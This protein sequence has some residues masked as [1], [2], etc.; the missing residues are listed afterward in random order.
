MSLQVLMPGVFNNENVALQG[1]LAKIFFP[2]ATDK[3]SSDPNAN[4]VVYELRYSF[5]PIYCSGTTNSQYIYTETSDILTV[6]SWKTITNLIKENDMGTTIVQLPK[7]STDMVIRYEI[8]ATINYEGKVSSYVQAPDFFI[9]TNHAAQIE[10]YIM[11]WIEGSNIR[12]SGRIVDLGFSTPANYLS[13]D[14][15]N[16]EHSVPFTQWRTDL[17]NIFGNI[18]FSYVFFWGE[19]NTAD[20]GAVTTQSKYNFTLKNRDWLAN[21]SVSIE[22][23]NPIL[24]TGYNLYNSDK[25]YYF[26]FH[27]NK[28]GILTSSKSSLDTNYDF[29]KNPVILLLNEIPL[30]QILKTGLKANIPKINKTTVGGAIFARSNLQLIEQNEETSSS[31]AL[32]DYYVPLGEEDSIEQP[33]LGFYKTD[34]TLLGKVSIQQIGEN[35]T[36]IKN[37]IALTDSSNITVPTSFITVPGEG[38]FRYDINKKDSPVPFLKILDTEQVVDNLISYTTELPLSANQG[39]ILELNKVDKING[40]GLST[41]DFTNALKNKLDSLPTSFYTKAESD[42]F[43]FPGGQGG[44]TSMSLLTKAGAYSMYNTS[45]YPSNAGAYGA[46]LVLKADGREI[47]DTNFEDTVQVYFGSSGQQEMFYR[48]SID[49]STW[50]GWKKV[51]TDENLDTTLSSSGVQ[52]V[53]NSR[54]RAVRVGKV[55]SGYVKSGV[56]ISAGGSWIL[57]SSQY[58][59][60]EMRPSSSIYI[61]TPFHPSSTQVNL[62][63]LRI[64]T[65][66]DILLKCTSITQSGSITTNR[67]ADLGFNMAFS[68]CV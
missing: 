31:V 20:K 29:V 10:P 53:D 66:G 34:N 39:R 50:K 13:E 60:V 63:E 59:P 16:G 9:I 23:T 32:Y 12:M 15:R 4:T 44:S 8:A 33:S 42:E 37:L 5:Q 41:N 51:V 18:S 6:T 11:E 19:D 43:Y 57:N 30:L 54:V 22:I 65:D 61:G 24:G 62:W 49:S 40:K 3:N 7:F 55:V 52:I 48:S 38:L 2:L 21:D 26:K 46:A 45:N 64:H 1:N 35:A 25:T 17:S 58:L 27:L 28:T 67:N 36:G 14:I 68:F 47:T 56:S